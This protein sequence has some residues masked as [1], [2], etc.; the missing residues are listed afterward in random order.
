MNYHQSNK[1]FPT[2]ENL[3]LF[4]NTT[5][6]V[7]NNKFPKLADS[8][9]N[10]IIGVR[11][12]EL[13]NYEKIRK[14]ANP[15]EPFAGLCKLGWTIFGPDPY[16]KCKPTTR[17]NFVWLLDDMLEKKVDLLLHEFLLKSRMIL[18]KQLLLAIK[19]F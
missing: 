11:Q 4:K 7:K 6:L 13:I 15:G 3:R 14:P 9:L 2:R 16:L 1:N 17:C 19:S 12:T 8:C 18:I 10:L 5:N